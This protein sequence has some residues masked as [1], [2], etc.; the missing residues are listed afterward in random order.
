[1]FVGGAWSS[2]G[3]TTQLETVDVHP[4]HVASVLAG[5]ASFSQ[6]SEPPA[7][8]KSLPVGCSIPNIESTCAPTVVA[9][10]LDLSRL[11]PP[12]ATPATPTTTLAAPVTTTVA[13]PPTT[14]AVA[15][16]EPSPAPAQPVEPPAVVAMAPKYVEGW[17]ALVSSYFA[18]SDVDKA[19][20]VIGCESS[21]DPTAKNPT[22]S[23][24]GLFQHLGRF[25]P[26]RSV[27]AG[28][29]GADIFDPTANVA[30]A[31]WLVYQGGGWSHWNPSRHCW[32]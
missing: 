32:A 4:D 25:W 20:R 7:G 8:I 13:A 27:K 2:P 29:A 26:E 12:V 23:A 10:G 9:G 31:A 15:S 28:W 24:S 30:V 11:S 1:M 21:G 22:S 14:A 19:L 5:I 6:D 17:R 3:P 18:P 16:P